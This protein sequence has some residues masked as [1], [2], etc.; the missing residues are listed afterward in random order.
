MKRLICLVL[1][2]VLLL[3]MAACGGGAVTSA[4]GDLSGKQPVGVQ[5]EVPA[6]SLINKEEIT[7]E[8]FEEVATVD[9]EETIATLRSEYESLKALVDTF[10]K[11]QESVA[12]VEG[13]Y[14][15]TYKEVE[16]LCARMQEYSLCYAELL[17]KS[18]GSYGDKYDEFE[19]LY[20]VVYDDLAGEIYDEIYDGILDEIYSA[21]YDGVI[22]EAYDN[23]P[24]DKWSDARSDEYDMWSDARSDVY[25]VWSDTRSD[26]YD[27]YSD[28][29]SKL[30]DKEP[31]PIEK[32]IN[33]YRKD[34]E[35]LIGKI[36]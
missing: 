26:I 15:E 5:G 17:V 32:E 8:N 31:E 20:D 6:V 25:D 1:S 29:R 21:F 22:D 14:E 16:L 9:V 24:Y 30:W 33:D 7:L 2:T 23:V 19:D 35:K 10:E 4:S 11:Y 34:V 28:M 13:F 18:E 12:E 27:F 36:V 3:S